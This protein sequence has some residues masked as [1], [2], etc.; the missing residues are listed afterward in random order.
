MPSSACETRL[1]TIRLGASLYA[2]ICGWSRKQ[3]ATLKAE[4]P[5]GSADTLVQIAIR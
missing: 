5:D 3:V 1:K 2:L 4:K